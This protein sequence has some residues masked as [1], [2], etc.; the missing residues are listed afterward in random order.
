VQVCRRL[1]ELA[2]LGH[3]IETGKKVMST[4]GREEREWS[5]A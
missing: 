1:P 3:V 4:S 2:G 5:V